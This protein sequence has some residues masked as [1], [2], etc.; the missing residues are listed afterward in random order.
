MKSKALLL[1]FIF[2]CGVVKSTPAQGTG[3]RSPAD[4]VKEIEQ[5]LRDAGRADISELDAEAGQSRARQL[6]AQYATKVKASRPS[7]IDQIYLGYLYSLA[8]DV[9]N[10]LATLRQALSDA[11]VDEE[12]KQEVRLYLIRKLS[13]LGRIQEAEAALEVVPKTAIHA[14][15]TI[16]QAHMMLAIVYT[17]L[18]Q[19]E[20]ALNHLEQAMAAA[21]KSG[22]ISQ[23][24]TTA[25]SLAQFYVALNRQ[26][27][28]S[29][30][31]RQLKTDWERQTRY[32][33][34]ESAKTL[35]S[36]LK[37]INSGLAHLELLD[38]P[39]PEIA[40]VKWLGEP[41]TTLAQ[42]RGK[43]V[44]LELWA[45]WCPDCRGLIP[46]LR[47]WATHYAK[48]GFKLVAVTRYYGYNGREAGVASKEEEETFLVKFKRM[49]NL[50]YGTAIDD[51]Q[52]S[53]DAYSVTGIPTV[54]IID[55]AGRVRLV[56]TWHDNPYLCEFVIKKL[57]AEPAPSGN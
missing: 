23:I 54:A 3:Q 26:A 12:Y 39:A 52:R 10:A 17:K 47:D 36:A 1:V 31:L 48:D 42:L 27:D 34:G 40:T 6:A 38:K 49:R 21:Q 46:A 19:M 56:F 55:R 28:A 4:Y 22:L 13:E 2:F 35:E 24:W 32:A 33:S 37:H 50:P 8:N 7:G 16:S 25:V 44:A 20:K 14:D 30:L 29:T 15:R 53:F 9:D 11:T 41:P 57:L 45:A 43:V 51:G 18:G 5:I